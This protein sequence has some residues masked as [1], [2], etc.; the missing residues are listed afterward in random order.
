MSAKIQLIC[1]IYSF[2]FGVG[3]NLS[4]RLL[5]KLINRG[6]I[7]VKLLILI[8]YNVLIS[9]LYMYVLYMINDGKLHVYF[10]LV[11]IFGYYINVKWCKFIKLR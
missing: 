11:F 10:V 6:N 9:I 3:F 5:Y 7:L 4:N 2:C 8:I 1:L